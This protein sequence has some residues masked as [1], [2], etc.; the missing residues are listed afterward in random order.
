MRSTRRAWF[1]TLAGL[2]V[3]PFALQNQSPARRP[4]M[5]EKALSKLVAACERSG[6][7][8]DRALAKCI[9]GFR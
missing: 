1:G 5:D 3:A 9:E 4:M 8:M 6:K 2:A 7:A